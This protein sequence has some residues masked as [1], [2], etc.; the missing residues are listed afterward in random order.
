[1]DFSQEDSGR[2]LGDA[3]VVFAQEAWA[4]LCHEEAGESRLM[5]RDDAFERLGRNA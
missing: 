4:Q 3:T 5:Y 2:D 1:V